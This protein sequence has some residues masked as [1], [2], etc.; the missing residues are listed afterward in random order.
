[1]QRDP[2][3]SEFLLVTDLLMEKVYPLPSRDAEGHR[4]DVKAWLKDLGGM[5]APLESSWRTLL[6]MR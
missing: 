3:D 1:M 6:K 2:N 5:N 4:F